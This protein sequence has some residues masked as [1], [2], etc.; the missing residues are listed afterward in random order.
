MRTRDHRPP[1]GSGAAP[2]PAEGRVQF[3]R[4]YRP[5]VDH[6]AQRARPTEP[7]S[8][9]TS[10]NLASDSPTF[11]ATPGLRRHGHAVARRQLVLGA[12]SGPPAAGTVRVSHASAP[13]VARAAA[14]VNLPE[15][16]R[17]PCPSKSPLK[18]STVSAGDLTAGRPDP[19]LTTA[20]HQPPADT[21]TSPADGIPSP[22]ERLTAER[23]ERRRQR[24]AA[25]EARKP[26][27]EPRPARRRERPA[28]STSALAPPRRMTLRGS[29]SITLIAVLAA[30][31]VLGTI[32]GA[33]GAAGW[34]IGL[35]VAGLTAVLSAVLR[36]CSRLT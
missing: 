14:S 13:A 5:A 24:A 20:A 11:S 26:P 7:A 31:G 6:T 3:A 15:M 34:V 30:G 22:A 8:R 9:D 28:E 25:H 19:D 33:L 17:A 4:P 35:L 18:A 27:R 21:G 1:V 2:L 36:R 29:V 32:L 12:A 10:G 23:T 16:R